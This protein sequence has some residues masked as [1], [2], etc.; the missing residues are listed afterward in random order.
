MLKWYAFLAV[1][2]TFATGT[3]IGQ[4]HGAH[5]T[6]PYSGFE[7]RTIKSLS[8]EDINELRRGGGWGFALPAELNGLPGPAHVLELKGDLGLS[9][10]QVAAVQEIYDEMKQEA[11]ARGERFI[12][13]E[14]A[15]S[16]AFEADD[17][18]EVDLRSHIEAT[19]KA[20]ADL[21]YVHLARH[22]STAKLLTE[23]QIRQYMILRGYAEDPCSNVPAGHSAE[24]WRKHNGCE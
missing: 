4:D 22:L 20:R 9:A 13:M 10:E 8:D 5:H 6:T 24:M 11:V 21:R 1:L 2:G 17:L 19:E 18:S 14:A 15:L 3:A 23:D 16:Q 7:D 12:E